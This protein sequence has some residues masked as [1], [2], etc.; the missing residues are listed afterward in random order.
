MPSDEALTG[1]LTVRQAAAQVGCSEALVR[2]LVRAEEVP[3]TRVQTPSGYRYLIDSADLPVLAHKVSMRRGPTGSVT[4]LR[5]DSPRGEG[6][7]AEDVEA[8]RAERDRLADEVRW[9]RAQVGEA[10]DRLAAE[11][12]TVAAAQATIARLALP[13]HVPPEQ[14]RSFWQRLFGRG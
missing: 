13:E 7:R 10:H 2:K 6:E 4:P 12:A 14:P 8:L 1:P 9:L 11:Q 5:R 3:A